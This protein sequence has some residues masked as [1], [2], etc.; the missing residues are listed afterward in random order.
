MTNADRLWEDSD[1]NAL[2]YFTET[3]SNPVFV[4]LN[5][6]PWY[7]METFLG[8]IEQK[9]SKVRQLIKKWIKLDFSN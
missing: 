6:M 9:R 3:C 1:R 5:H 7:L 2:H 8:E 4:I